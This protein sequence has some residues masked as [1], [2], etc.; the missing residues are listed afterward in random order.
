[1]TEDST[2]ISDELQLAQFPPWKPPLKA[3]FLTGFMG[4]GK[5]TIGRELA[6]AMHCRFIDLDHE[7]EAAAGLSITQIFQAHGEPHFRELETKA[8]QCIIN[9]LSPGELYVIALGGGTIVQPANSSLLAASSS[10][11]IFLDA[12]IHDLYSRCTRVQN[13]PLFR[14]QVEFQL[15]YSRRL[16]HYQQAHLH[17]T[18][19][20]KSSLQIAQEIISALQYEV[21]L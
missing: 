4:A 14:D 9:S 21:Q 6:S 19:S 11:V 16:R 13:R 5:T 8:L 20:G 7:I 17:I 10:P 15:L 3:L 1:M 2:A 18:T 12:P